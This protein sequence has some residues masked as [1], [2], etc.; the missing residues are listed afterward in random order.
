M[1]DKGEIYASSDRTSSSAI[2]SGND[3]VAMCLARRAAEFQGLIA[4]ERMEALQVVRYEQSQEFTAHFDWRGNS[5]NDRE[6]SFFGVLEADCENC[7]TQFPNLMANWPAEDNRWCNLVDCEE[8]AMLTF[9]AVS[10]SALFW[11]N[12]HPNG[13]GDER[14]LHAGLPVGNG[15][16]YGLNIWTHLYG[17]Y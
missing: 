10:G 15:T 6:T 8:N 13:T 12:L 17:L 7:G 5:P 1:D 16:K 3:S 9:K 11:K 4:P 14:T 2:I